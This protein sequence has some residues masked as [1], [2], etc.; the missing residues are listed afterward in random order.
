[1]QKKTKN[2]FRDLSI[3]LQFLKFSITFVLFLHLLY[4]NL[5]EIK[6]LLKNL[7]LEL[8]KNIANC[9]IIFY[10]SQELN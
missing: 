7:N 3:I 4:N 8:I 9:S 1:M 2:L 6:C 10:S 5:F